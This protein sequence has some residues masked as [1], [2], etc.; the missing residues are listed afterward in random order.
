MPSN[1]DFLIERAARWIGCFE[2]FSDQKYKDL[3]R[4]GD[5]TVGYGC[6]IY[7]PSKDYII[8][9]EGVRWSLHTGQSYR[10]TESGEKII[11]SD[12]PPVSKITVMD[13]DGNKVEIK[14]DAGKAYLTKKHIPIHNE[15]VDL[16][17]PLFD[18]ANAKL[19]HKGLKREIWDVINAKADFPVEYARVVQMEYIEHY[20]LPQLKKVIPGFDN[21]PMGVK[22]VLIDLNYQYGPD[23]FNEK[24]DKFKPTDKE[25]PGFW[26]AMAQA[27]GKGDIDKAA[28]ELESAEKYSK[29]GIRARYNRELLR[30]EANG[31]DITP[32]LEPIFE[33]YDAALPLPPYPHRIKTKPVPEKT[34]LSLLPELN[35]PRFAYQDYPADTPPSQAAVPLNPAKKL[36]LS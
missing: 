26:Y 13:A 23:E 32:F 36:V 12:K 3:N 22:L 10:I 7:Q 20:S 29:Y 27:L 24:A 17:A 31:A 19:A 9:V 4:R 34:P 15:Q 8:D 25:R 5:I 2:G 11:L 1:P 21:L 14:P 6:T 16:Y 28:V 30:L 35:L 33:R 18:H